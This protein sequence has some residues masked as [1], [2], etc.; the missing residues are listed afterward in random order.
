MVNQSNI[1]KAQELSV[2]IVRHIHNAQNDQ[3][4]FNAPY[5]WAAYAYFEKEN[6]PVPPGVQK[7]GDVKVPWVPTC[8]PGPTGDI[9]KYVINVRFFTNKDAIDAFAASAA[10][11]AFTTDA[12]GKIAK[13]AFAAEIEPI[14]GSQMLGW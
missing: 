1:E 3:V 9:S 2:E 12:N 13:Y 5:T 14:A 7:L 4:K 10:A 6:K 11:T 8:Q